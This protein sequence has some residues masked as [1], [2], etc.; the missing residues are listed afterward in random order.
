[1][2]RRC[3]VSMAILL[4]L[5][6]LNRFCLVPRTG[7]RLLAWH[8]A[9]ALAGGV[10]A[11]SAGA[12]AGALRPPAPPAGPGMGVSSGLR[13]LLG[14][15]DAPLSAPVGVGPPGH[16]GGVAGRHH[17][18]GPSAPP[19]MDTPARK[20]IASAH[21]TLWLAYSRRRSFSHSVLRTY[22]FSRSRSR[23]S[24]ISDTYV[25]PAS[26]SSW[27]ILWQEWKSAVFAPAASAMLSATR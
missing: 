9:D 2:R 25:A 8:G 1:M 10:D 21:C 11:V 16:S 15:C 20:Q 3:L 22:R 4:A 27:E 14:V 7:S 17:D 24:C 18:A 12:F 23:F 26:R 13:S 6:G 5:Y 19:P